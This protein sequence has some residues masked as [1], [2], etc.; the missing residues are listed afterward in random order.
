MPVISAVFLDM[1]APCRD[2]P[3]NPDGRSASVLQRGVW[4]STR[5]VAGS[6]WVVSQEGAWGPGPPRAVT[7]VVPKVLKEVIAAGREGKGRRPICYGYGGSL[8]PNPKDPAL[9]KLAQAMPELDVLNVTLPAYSTFRFS[10]FPPAD[11]RHLQ[12]TRESGKEFWF[13]ESNRYFR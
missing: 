9:V 5:D 8:T 13:V 10:G 7:A 2:S 3:A 4:Y 12:A 11:P 6:R 1:A